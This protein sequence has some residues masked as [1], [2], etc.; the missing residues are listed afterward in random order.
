MCVWVVSDCQ[1][2]VGATARSRSVAPVGGYGR[3]GP[4]TQGSLRFALGFIPS[5]LRGY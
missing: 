4:A 5:P 2:V 3:D 1:S